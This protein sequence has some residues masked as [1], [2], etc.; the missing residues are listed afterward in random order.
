VALEAKALGGDGVKVPEAYVAMKATYQTV[1]K[2]TENF[3]TA[4]GHAY[5]QLR[6][7]ESGYIEKS[8]QT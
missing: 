3:I 6:V 7:C 1:V 8:L 4:F 5:R 2:V